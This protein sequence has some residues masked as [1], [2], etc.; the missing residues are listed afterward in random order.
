MQKLHFQADESGFFR[1]L[2]Q[3]VQ[4]Y[5]R[6]NQLKTYA[7]TAYFVKAGILLAVDFIAW[8]S[9]LFADQIWQMVMACVVMGVLHVSIFLNIFHD[10]AHRAIF[11]RAKW[12]DLLFGLFSLMGTSS[13]IWK[14]RHV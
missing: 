13:K 2:R 9:L 8:L 3:A 10:A 6:Q 5:F 14:H 1:E 4:T 12:N 7:N 11:K